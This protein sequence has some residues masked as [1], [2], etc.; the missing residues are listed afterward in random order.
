MLWYTS[1]YDRPSA[2]LA[3]YEGRKVYF[4]LIDDGYHIGIK[5]DEY[6]DLEKYKHLVPDTVYE[7]LMLNVNSPEYW[8]EFDTGYAC[9]DDD[10]IEILI[11][12]TYGL[13]EL[14]SDILKEYEARYQEFRDKVGY[15]CDCHPKL[16]KPFVQRDTEES[17]EYWKIHR[18]EHCEVKTKKLLRTVY[19]SDFVPWAD[20]DEI[21]E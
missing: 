2:G 5:C 4:A 14:D 6:K 18:G 21:P 8:T 7:Q 1:F 20:T 9:I 17:K 11:Y 16:Y 13:Y 12:R 19:M 10:E 15:H 3:L